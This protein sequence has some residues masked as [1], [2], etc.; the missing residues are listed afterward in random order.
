MKEK[1]HTSHDPEI[2]RRRVIL[3]IV[4]LVGITSL[5]AAI[6]FAAYFYQDTD[7]NRFSFLRHYI[8]ELGRFSVSET[9][10]TFNSLLIFGSLLLIPFFIELGQFLGS[11]ASKLMSSLSI[12][13]MIGIFFVGIFSM[14]NPAYHKRAAIVFFAA[15]FLTFLTFFL[16]MLWKIT[17]GIRVAA[18]Y[19]FHS[20][21][22]F[23]VSFSFLAAFADDWRRLN[24]ILFEPEKFIRPQFWYMAV[25]EWGI[26]FGIII[27]F[28]AFSIEMLRA[29]VRL[30][31]I[32]LESRRHPASKLQG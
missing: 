23:W 21:Y 10:R 6:L 20:I 12:Y 26:F 24:Q 18:F 22:H 19:L 3:S 32:A 15:S 4:G 7:G 25:A 8:S 13:T 5:V 30:P 1:F 31:E 2:R 29:N 11:S 9:A 16:E 14:D 17:H 28:Y 27:L